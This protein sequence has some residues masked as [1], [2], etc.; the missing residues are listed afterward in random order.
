MRLKWW[1]NMKPFKLQCILNFIVQ[2]MF[3]EDKDELEFNTFVS[4]RLTS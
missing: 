2:I 1:V 3:V 4:G